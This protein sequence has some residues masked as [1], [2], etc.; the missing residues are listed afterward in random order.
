VPK[1]NP[2]FEIADEVDLILRNAELT[3]AMTEA[4]Q[5]DDPKAARAAKDELR[6]FRQH[7]REV[8]DW[9]EFCNLNDVDPADGIPSPAAIAASAK[10]LEV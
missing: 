3:K 4:K 2:D 9:I 1:T 5:G 10:A 7:W 6:A 8:R